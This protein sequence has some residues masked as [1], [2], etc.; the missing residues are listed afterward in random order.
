MMEG[1]R[2]T[3]KKEEKNI[4]F[5]EAEGE[6]EITSRRIGLL[7]IAYARTLVDEFGEEEGKRLILKAIRDYGI[8]VG[9]WMVKTGKRDLPRFGM[10]ERRESVEVNGEKRT[11]AYG[12]VLAKVWRE[13]GE[14]ELGR[15]YCY[16]DPVKTMTANPERKLIHTQ[17]EPC[18][19]PFCELVYRPT[20]EKE[21]KNL[22]EKEDLDPNLDPHL[23]E[24][25]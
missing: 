1:V 18:G 21:L 24:C 11:R 2:M 12:C 15:L 7:H 19:D 6:V 3:E 14:N 13:Q 8:R 17:V 16:I 22:T 25:K 4:P 5:A 10:H 20:T 23:I 9:K